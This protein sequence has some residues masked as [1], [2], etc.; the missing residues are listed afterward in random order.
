MPTIDELVREVKEALE[1]DKAPFAR[2]YR[3]P[4][5]FRRRPS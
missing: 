3:R 1:A 4:A 2:P 5:A